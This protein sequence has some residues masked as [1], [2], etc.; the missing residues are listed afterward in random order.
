MAR[1]RSDPVEHA[2]VL[3]DLQGARLE[4]LAARAGKEPRTAFDGQGGDA[5]PGE[6]ECEGE[7]GGP[8]SDD[9]DVRVRA[10]RGHDNPLNVVK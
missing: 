6:V 4:S 5:V 9:Q 7:A 3:Q 2:E 1:D 8:G 10:V